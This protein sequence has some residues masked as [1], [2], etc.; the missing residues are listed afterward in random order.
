MCIFHK[1]KPIKTYTYRD[2]S[3]SDVGTIITTI[4]YQCSKCLEIK[5]KDVYGRISLDDLINN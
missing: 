2:T 3:W 5:E 1:Y 4:Y